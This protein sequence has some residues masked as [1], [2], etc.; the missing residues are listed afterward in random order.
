MKVLFVSP[1]YGNVWEPLG[2]G[3]IISYCKKHNLGVEFDFCHGNFDDN[4]TIVNKGVN[5]DIVAFSATSP[6]VSEA[7]RLAKAIKEKNPNVKTILGGWHSTCLFGESFP[8]IDYSIEGEGEYYFSTLLTVLV[9]PHVTKQ[10]YKYL[11]F[12]EL[13]WPDRKAIKQERHLELCYQMCGLRIG[14][15]QSRRGCPMEC[16]FCGECNMTEHNVRVRDPEDTLDEIDAVNTDYHIDMFKFVDPTWCYPKS[17]A[18]DFCS[19]K[20]RRRN[21]LPWEAMGHAAFLTKDLLKFMKESNCKQ[22]NIGVESGNQQILNDMNKGVTKEKIKKV[23][24]WCHELGLESRGFFLFG[25][26]NDTLKTAEETFDFVK[27]INPDVFGMTLLCP[28]PGTAFY[29]HGKYHNIDWSKA[30]EYQNDFWRTD[31]F[32]NDD[33]KRVQK[34]FYKAFKNK[35]APHM[36]DFF[37]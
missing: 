25:M 32:T 37:K 6:T 30:D 24:D 17:A 22:I 31:N 35:I 13:P 16:A 23:F 20:I 12:D 34:V 3:Y 29:D 19:S 33:L 18:Y 5:S 27:E 7:L 14:S 11:Y 15:F 28:Y 21:N 8:Y 26:P 2:I 4:A 9:N 10:P 36:K 1:F